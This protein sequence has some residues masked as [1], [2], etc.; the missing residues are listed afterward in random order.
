[1]AADG[2][3]DSSRL[4]VGERG[5]VEPAQR[6]EGRRKTLLLPFLNETMDVQLE[7]AEHVRSTT[8]AGGTVLL[9]LRSGKYFALNSVGS[10]LWQVVVAGSSRDAVLER[11]AAHFPDVPAERLEYDADALL[12]QLQAKGLLRPRRDTAPQS[13][14]P[15]APP[16]TAAPPAE[17]PRTGTEVRA[18][19]LWFPLAYLGLLAADAVLKLRGFSRLHALV[20][21]APVRSAAR[22]GSTRARRI[23][24]S[25]D[26]AAAFY[27]KS[28]WCLQRSAVTVALLRLAGFP[29][30]LVIGV[31]RVPFYAHAWAELDGQVVNDRPAVRQEYEVLETC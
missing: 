18:S 19:A 29:A 14:T 24:R 31:R 22:P 9:D 3:P 17:L 30:R 27:F 28:A 25:V 20:Q 5:G 13:P 4:G 26:R 15:A 10:L 2:L 21:R 16:E 23:V 8:G 6:V 11:L 7:S 12:S 1:M